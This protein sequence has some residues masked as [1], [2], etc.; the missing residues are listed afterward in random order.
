MNF[1]KKIKKTKVEPRLYSQVGC[2]QSCSDNVSFIPCKIG[3]RQGFGEKSASLQGFGK[4]EC[5]G[6]EMK[7]DGVLVS[8]VVLD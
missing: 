7:V 1:I 8:P 5:F 6:G 4:N 3:I 2:A